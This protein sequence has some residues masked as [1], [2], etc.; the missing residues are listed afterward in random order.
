MWDLSTVLEAMKG[1]PIQVRANPLIRHETFVVQDSVSYG[2]C[3]SEAH[4]GF[5]SALSKRDMYGIW[6]K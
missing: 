3:F 6:A 1:D 5:T 2:S 4:R